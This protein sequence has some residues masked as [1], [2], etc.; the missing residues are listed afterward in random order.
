[1]RF[2]RWTGVCAGVLVAAYILFESP[3]SGMSMNPARSLAS[4]LMARDFRA[5]WIYF[6]APPLGMLA[7]ALLHGRRRACAKLDH[8][9]SARCIFCSQRPAPAQRP[10]RIVILG[11]GFGGVFAAQQL[12][13]LLR[14]LGDYEVV[15][16]AKDNYFV[17]QP[18][19]PEV[20]SGTIGLLDL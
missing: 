8:V 17:F 15:L 6:L 18:M 4:A 12:E 5:L 20:I 16:V 1:S 9:P 3:I 11:G 10:K 13:K 19:L 2:A 7:A 14:G